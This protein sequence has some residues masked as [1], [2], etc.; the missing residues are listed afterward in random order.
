[1]PKKLLK[2]RFEATNSNMQL[3]T[4]SFGSS[5]LAPQ[6]CLVYQKQLCQLPVLKVYMNTLEY[7]NSSSGN[8]KRREQNPTHPKSN[9]ELLRTSFQQSD[10]Q[11][12]ARTPLPSCLA[13]HRKQADEC[14]SFWFEN[15]LENRNTHILRPLA[16]TTGSELCLF[17]SEGQREARL[18]RSQ[19]QGATFEQTDTNAPAKTTLRDGRLSKAGKRL[20]FL[21]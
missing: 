9:A 15:T 2:L 12:Q 8:L 6:P 21:K 13:G 20:G 3:D 17:A 5:A 10:T 19:Y 14:C 7:T 1:M 18:L 4:L 11:T 16:E